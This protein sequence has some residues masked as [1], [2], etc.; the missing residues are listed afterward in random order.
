MGQPIVGTTRGAVG[1]GIADLRARS[2]PLKIGG[3]EWYHWL[4]IVLLI[5]LIA[6]WVRMRRK[7]T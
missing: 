3:M 4:L 1:N 6:F 5:V 2:G 7:G